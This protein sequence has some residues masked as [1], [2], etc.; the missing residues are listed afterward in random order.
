MHQT[1]GVPSVETPASWTVA[2]V[3]LVILALSFGAP[4]ITIIALKMIAAELGGLRSVPAFATA[5]AWVGFGTGGIA[6]GDVAERVGVRAT[7]IT[8]AVMVCIGLALSTGGGTWQ[9]S[10]GHGLFVG[11]R[12]VAGMEGAV[13][14][15]LERGIDRR[16][17]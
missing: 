15:Y 6:M 11:F 13:Y 3:E 1:I 17:S 7:V 4:W 10:A 8:G 2:T 12:G 16:R 14:V 5:L 9:L